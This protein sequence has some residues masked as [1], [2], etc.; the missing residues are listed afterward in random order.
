MKSVIDI[1]DS[2]CSLRRRQLSVRAE[3]VVVRHGNYH[4]LCDV[5]DF[6]G[7]IPWIE[8]ESDLPSLDRHVV[9]LHASENESDW[10]RLITR[11]AARANQGKSREVH[12]LTYSGGNA[13]LE[14]F[15]VPDDALGTR[16]SAE[17]TSWWV[18]YANVRSRRDYRGADAES[19]GLWPDRPPVEAWLAKV[20]RLQTNLISPATPSQIAS[21]AEAFRTREGPGLRHS[22]VNAVGPLRESLE[23]A[24]ATGTPM[25]N[26]SVLWAHMRTRLS[27]LPSLPP[28]IMALVAD[29]ESTVV[30]RISNR[31][32]TSAGLEELSCRLAP[33]EQFAAVIEEDQ[34]GWE[35]LADAEMFSG[36]ESL[37]VLWI[38]DEQA[39]YDALRPAFAKFGI[40][41]QYCGSV[42]S[43]PSDAELTSFG[44]IV[45]DLIMEGQTEAAFRS[46]ARRG[47]EADKTIDDTSAG[48]TILQIIQAL[49]LPPPV[50]VLSA[51]ES[52]T[53]IRACTVLGARNYFVKGRGDYL[54]L[55][56]ELKR[57]AT[58]TQK[59]HAS[60]LRP[61]NS[62]LV[63]GNMQDP[64][65]DT[66]SLIDNIASSGFR[67]PVMFCGEPGVG[68]EEL[69]KELHLRSA[70]R[71][72]PFLVLNCA[73]LV[74]TLIESELVGDET[75]AATGRA[76]LLS[77][78]TGGILFVDDID[79]LDASFQDSLLRATEKFFVQRGSAGHDSQAGVMLVVSSSVDPKSKAGRHIFSESL[80]A[81]LGKFILRIP[82]LR[83]R[84]AI[85]ADLA[86]TVLVR[87]A[88]EL[89]WS[90]RVLLPDA[91]AWL[92][93]EAE[94]GR[95]DGQQGNIRGL[96][97]LLERALVCSPTSS[98]LGL[99]ELKLAAELERPSI[100][101][102]NAI[103][104]S[105][106]LI[107]Q[108][109]INAGGGVLKDLKDALEAELL[110]ELISRTDRQTTASMLGSSDVNLRQSIKKLR[111][112]G[113][114]PWEL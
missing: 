76:G 45:V 5:R 58:A 28:W 16:Y 99:R 61:A 63:V 113:Y 14:C 12:L 36:Q 3:R 69:A 29:C 52:P 55:L 15:E 54:R 43:L 41:P 51:R 82:A 78:A 34:G 6:A 39:W 92:T 97:T 105:G 26:L 108:E 107:A 21:E 22:L 48:L 30:N 44:A 104:E 109:V 1:V 62:R 7:V 111:D 9:L 50:F 83:E 85:T 65:V 112:K 87:I 110:R 91:L 27:R 88:S 74:P 93:A 106:R 72:M 4:F 13:P 35:I 68:K 96:Y 56:V 114:W 102:I 17:T 60:T 53:I 66:L 90:P 42:N 11:L 10:R 100:K 37:R 47:L 75:G 89:G 71:S 81:R 25:S 79:T 8:S 77:S 98:E 80:L 18:H 59:R 32:D 86:R 64:L 33:I 67:G 101:P 84:A 40:Q 103:R 23:Y 46:L 73:T 57:E 19:V 2:Q 70:R 95:F 31:S 20:F 94:R 24:L 49:P 38:D